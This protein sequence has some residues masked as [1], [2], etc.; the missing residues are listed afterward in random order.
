MV[1]I[2]GVPAEM[3]APIS[4]AHIQ[5]THTDHIGVSVQCAADQ[6]SF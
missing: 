3:H 4:D 1:A 2:Q 5:C 6:L